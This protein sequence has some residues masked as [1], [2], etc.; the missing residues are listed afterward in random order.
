MRPVPAA[1][2]LA[3]HGPRVGPGSRWPR[4]RGHAPKGRASARRCRRNIPA[5]S[6]R[7]SRPG[8]VPSPRPGAACHYGPR[9]RRP[10]QGR[11]QA[12]PQDRAASLTRT[13]SGAGSGRLAATTAGPW[14]GAGSRPRRRRRGR[15]TPVSCPGGAGQRTASADRVFAVAWVAGACW[16]GRAGGFGWLFALPSAGGAAAGSCLFSVLVL[17][18]MGWAVSFPVSGRRLA[19]AT[20]RPWPGAG[21]K[22]W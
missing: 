4:C 15:S 3:C 14:P 21:A 20:P 8:G 9:R 13:A 19:W 12:G 1:V 11:P 17:L 5:E 22:R 6:R 2:T 16:C 7:R 10:G 18:R